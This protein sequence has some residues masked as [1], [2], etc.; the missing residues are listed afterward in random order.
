MTI[1]NGI[2]IITQLL[3]AKAIAT[4]RK[5]T[6]LSISEIQKRSGSEEYLIEKGLSDDKSL[7]KMIKLAKAS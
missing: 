1:T 6:G 3:P 4:I 2:K 5:A 7:A